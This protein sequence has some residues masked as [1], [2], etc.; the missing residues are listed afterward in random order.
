M[1]DKG[2]EL[3]AFADIL[4]LN[5]EETKLT[6]KFDNNPELQQKKNR[7]WKDIDGNSRYK[8]HVYGHFICWYYNGAPSNCKKPESECEDCYLKKKYV[9]EPPYGKVKDISAEKIY[10]THMKRP[11][12][13]LWFVEAFKMLDKNKKRDLFKEVEDK[14]KETESISDIKTILAKYDITW[15]TVKTEVQ[16]YGKEHQVI[17]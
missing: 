16:K 12:L 10:N 17:K 8:H 7:W 13:Y 15:E 1:S 9:H 5:N 14:W 4:N 2:V 11:E 3:K 6:D